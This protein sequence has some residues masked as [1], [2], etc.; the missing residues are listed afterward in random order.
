LNVLTN[1]RGRL[2]WVEC[3][4]ASDICFHPSLMSFELPRCGLP[5]SVTH[6]DD[7][8][9]FWIRQTILLLFFPSFFSLP[10]PW[11]PCQVLLKDQ[12]GLSNFFFFL[13]SNL[14]IILLIVVF[15]NYFFFLSISSFNIW[16]VR[17]VDS[18]IFLCSFYMV[19]SISCSKWRVFRVDV[20][21]F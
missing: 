9:S 13:L 6:V 5:P 16:F 11:F 10:S 19:I 12:N 1:R 7:K 17:K 20:N 3:V 14:I 2:T 18:L 4:A 21:L 15:T 8:C